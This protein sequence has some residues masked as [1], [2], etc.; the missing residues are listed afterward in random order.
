MSSLA[1]RLVGFQCLLFGFLLFG[2]CSSGQSAGDVSGDEE[3]CGIMFDVNG[4][5]SRPQTT[6]M[7]RGGAHIHLRNL[8][9]RRS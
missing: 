1:Y 2:T 9:R 3:R 5:G 4:E 6:M 8:A 7:G